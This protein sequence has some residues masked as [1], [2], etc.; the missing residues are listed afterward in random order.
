MFPIQLSRLLRFL[1]PKLP[2]SDCPRRGRLLFKA[3]DPSAEAP[4]RVI[5]R[6]SKRVEG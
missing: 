1:E 5:K 2:E 6:I 3:V 4:A